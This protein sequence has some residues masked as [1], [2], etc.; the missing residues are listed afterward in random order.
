MYTMDPMPLI[1]SIE[2]YASAFHDFA[3]EHDIGGTSTVTNNAITNDGKDNPSTITSYNNNNS[4]SNNIDVNIINYN[5]MFPRPLDNGLHTD[6]SSTSPTNHMGGDRDGHDIPF[7]IA[8]I[9][10]PE[11]QKVRIAAIPL[12]YDS[13]I[14]NSAGAD[15]H[16]MNLD[17]SFN[18]VDDNANADTSS[19]SDNT[20]SASTAPSSDNDNDNLNIILALTQN[21]ISPIDS[22]NTRQEQYCLQQNHYQQQQGLTKTVESEDKINASSIDHNST[23]ATTSLTSSTLINQR[24]LNHWGVPNVSQLQQQQH[25]HHVQQQP[26]FAS[27][28]TST[29]VSTNIME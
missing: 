27:A 25:V 28:A 11:L 8:S 24:V 2:I 14:I 23:I 13:S 5:Q 12:T 29:A 7:S 19:N 17:E 21:L 4:S 10:R 3:Y 6:H 20:S 26:L 18:N 16:S 15:S 9:F 1:P 22:M